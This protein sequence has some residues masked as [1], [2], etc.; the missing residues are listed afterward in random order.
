MRYARATDG[1]MFDKECAERNGKLFT[2][3]EAWGEIRKEHPYGT[4][5]FKLVPRMQFSIETVLDMP[6]DVPEGAVCFYDPT[7]SETAYMLRDQP[8]E[9]KDEF[10]RKVGEVVMA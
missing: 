2:I 10:L 1:E 5:G 4:L 3:K 7:V 8:Q 9:D 6:P